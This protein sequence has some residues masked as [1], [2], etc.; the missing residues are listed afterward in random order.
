MKVCHAG[1][2]IYVQEG[3]YDKFLKA[4]TAEMKSRTIGDQWSGSD[5]GNLFL[6]M[7]F[8]EESNCVRL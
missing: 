5:Q 6:A 3:I 2:R 1:S 7:S 8:S 4:F